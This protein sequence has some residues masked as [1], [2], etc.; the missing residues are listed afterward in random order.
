M[1]DYKETYGVKDLSPDS[2][3]DL[4][5]RIKD[6][7]SLAKLWLSNEFRLGREISDWDN[8][9]LYCKLISSEMH[10]LEACRNL[11]GEA[12]VTNMLGDTFSK[13]S[14]QFWADYLI[15]NWVSIGRKDVRE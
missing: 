15:S 9:E 5:S 12:Q 1:D 13:K 4:A 2:M 8:T 7:A 3:K 10:E 11:N 14:G 6:D